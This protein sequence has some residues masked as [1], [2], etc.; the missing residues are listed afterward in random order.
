MTKWFLP[1]LLAATTLPAISEAR[2][3][4]APPPAIS[5]RAAAGD[6]PDNPG[7]LATDLS[8]AMKPAAI[9]KAMRKVADWQLQASESRYNTQWTFA[10]L[11]DG[12]LAAS[13]ITGDPRYRDRV[14][15][16]AQQNQWKLGARFS[17]ADDEAIGLTYLAFYAENHAPERLAPTSE[18]M[19]K[20]LARPDDPEANLWWWCDALYMAPPV[21][22]QLSLATGDHKY[23]EYMDH[24]W[25]LTSAALYDPTEHLFFRDKRY[26]TQHE[27][28]GKKIFWSRGN[29]WV[30]AALAMVLERMPEKDPLRPRY[31]TQYRQMAERLAGLQQS[32]GLWRA[33]LLDPGAYASPEVSGSAFYTYAMAWGIHH[34][35]L[36]RKKYLP[37]VTKS[38]A[39]MLTHVYQDGRLGS[40]QPIGGAPDKFG[41]SSSYVYGVGAFLLAGSELTHITGGK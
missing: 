1:F 20:L 33:G 36:D 17:H 11:Y 22:A 15:L 10:A 8:P 12:L 41:P 27:A 29:G 35:I 19:D 5:E 23:L 14:L 2:A 24:E 26:L 18:E 25:W 31:L 30:F 16:V 32:D 4:S 9:L 39:G 40:I 3:Q 21:L 28:N 7:P 37:V 38:W 34:R 6:E 13:E